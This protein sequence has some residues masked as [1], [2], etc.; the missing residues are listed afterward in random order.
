MNSFHLLK[1]Y[2]IKYDSQC[3]NAGDSMPLGGHD[4]GCNV[5]VENNELYVYMAQ[6]CK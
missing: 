3:Q 1:N 5:W 2:N 4:M 6:C